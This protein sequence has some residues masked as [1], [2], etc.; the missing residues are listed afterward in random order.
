MVRLLGIPLV[1]F[2]FSLTCLAQ[3]PPSSDIYLVPINPATSR[4]ISEQAINVT[5]RTGYDNQPFFLA[6]GSLLYTSIRDDNQA[7]IYRYHPDTGKTKRLTQTSESEYSPTL[8][9]DGKHFST[10][11]V[12]ANNEQRL[13]KF[14][15][16]GTNPEIL[17]N[18]VKAV[19]YHAWFSPKRLGLFIVGDP[20]TLQLVNLGEERPEVVLEN[21]GR[22]LSVIPGKDTISVVSKQDPDNW[23]LMAI[24]EKGAEKTLM[25]TLPGSEDYAW[26]PTG[27]LIMAQGKKLYRSTPLPESPWQPLADFSDAGFRQ[28][29]RLAVSHDGRTLAMV[30]AN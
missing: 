10:V 7:D 12:E 3:G 8:M 9:P 6:D 26:T 25:A 19:G 4:V 2:G 15:L 13:W 22:C 1:L 28:I 21:I 16:D 30:V 20:H 18:T 27:I 17:L 23:T 14:D 11:R 5:S 29:N 24:S